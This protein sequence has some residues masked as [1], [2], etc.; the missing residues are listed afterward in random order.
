MGNVL[1]DESATIGEGCLIGPD[2]SVGPGCIIEPGV[3][4]SRCTIMRGVKVKKHACVSGA[5]VG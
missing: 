1:I 5:I 4:L 3:R 2:V